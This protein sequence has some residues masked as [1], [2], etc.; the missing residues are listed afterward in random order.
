MG[1][2]PYRRTITTHNQGITGLKAKIF[3]PGRQFSAEASPLP[4]FDQLKANL[5]G[6][7]SFL[8]PTNEE[9]GSPY[10]YLGGSLY[11]ASGDRAFEVDLGLQCANDLDMYK[12]FAQGEHYTLSFESSD[13]GATP[14]PPRHGHF[15]MNQTVEVEA[16]PGYCQIALIVKGKKYAPGPE[17]GP[18]TTM[19]VIMTDNMFTS[20]WPP[21]YRTLHWNEASDSA[22][23]KWATSIAQA[24]RGQGQPK[25][26]NAD[27]VD[28]VSWICGV[29]WSEIQV[30]RAG[31]WSLVTAN[32]IADI[33]NYPSQLVM[34]S[35]Q[36]LIPP[37]T[38]LN[39]PIVV[40]RNSPSNEIVSID[41]RRGRSRETETSG[42]SG[43]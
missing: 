43:F 14:P 9:A 21:T 34:Q 3:L 38:W 26:I 32:D 35:G 36:P 30:Q 39:L 22:E 18:L 33:D 7:Q 42:G 13:P 23:F 40:Q 17:E 37:T 1:S 25:R 12:L 6:H 27:V 29:E 16:R 19:T 5:L 8:R 28:Q 2:G 20:Y 10:I 41:L 4:T 31:N 15:E 24:W 11:S